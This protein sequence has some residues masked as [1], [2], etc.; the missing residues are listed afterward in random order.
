MNRF[1]ISSLAMAVAIGGALA[2]AAGEAGAQQ[3]TTFVNIG[4]AGIGGG[5]YPTGGFICNAVNSNRQ[6]YGHNIRC[7]VESTAGSVGNL[8]AIAAGDLEVGISQADWQYHAYNGTSVFKDIGPQKNLRFVFS[9]H[10]DVIHVVTRKGAGVNNFTDLKGKT[11]NTG[12]VGS[13]TESTIYFAMGRYKFDPKTWLGKDTKLTSREQAS[14]VCDGKI[15]AFIYPTAITAA[16]ITEATNTCDTVIAN[17]WDGTVQGILKEFSY[18]ASVTIPAGTYR[19]QDKEVKTWGM[20]ATIVS[21]T[22]LSTDTVYF[23]TKAVFDNFEEFKKQ[24]TFFSG[25]T[26]EGAL[27]NGKSIPFHSGSEKY[28][29]EVGLLK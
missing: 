14:A 5:Y 24:A 7:T 21:T 18:Y 12:N 26:R 27:V 20:P 29:K 4:T 28:F 6:K 17:W 9:L 1:T 3:K 25:L 13:G 8:R 19:G 10:S 16:S 23:M 22:R 2:L 11:V 15:D